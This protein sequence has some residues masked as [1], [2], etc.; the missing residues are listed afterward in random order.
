MP[1]LFRSVRERRARIEMEPLHEVQVRHGGPAVLFPAAN[2]T[3]MK[4]Q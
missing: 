2:A 3:R 1:F 4:H